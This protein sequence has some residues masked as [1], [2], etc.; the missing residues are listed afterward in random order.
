MFT[1]A[2]ARLAGP[3]VFDILLS[4]LKSIG[5]ID[6]RMAVSGFYLNSGDLNKEGV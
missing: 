6:G 4:R 3:R 1:A 5:I 2:Y